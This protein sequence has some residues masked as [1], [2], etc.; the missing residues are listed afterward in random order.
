MARSVLFR[1]GHSDPRATPHSWY[2]RDRQDA[3]QRL[4]ERLTHYRDEQPIVLALPRGGVPVGYEIARS[5]GAPLDVF[6]VRKLG[7]PGHRE[8]GIG[9]VAWG[10]LTI[11]NEAAIRALGITRAQIEA[12]AVEEAAELERRLRRFRGDRPLPD[13]RG[14]TVILVD[15]GLATGV[16]ALAA[17]RAI[18]ELQPR[19]I[20]LAVPVCA[21]E[22]AEALRPEVDDLI[23]VETPPEFFAV[24]FW[25]RNFDQTVDEEVVDLLDRARREIEAS[26]TP[27]ADSGAHGAE[28]SGQTD[29]TM[30]DGGA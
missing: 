9:A 17:I 12:I 14:R 3:G 13:V 10:G 6:L 21:P 2:F 4:A 18:R 8:L 24:G 28:P 30:R 1:A 7:A 22:T 25:Y 16:T 15:D 23:C 29:G 11:L 26:Q 19:R 27:P 20:V 5:L